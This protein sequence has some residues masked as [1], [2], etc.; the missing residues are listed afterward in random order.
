LLSRREARKIIVVLFLFFA[1]PYQLMNAFSINHNKAYDSYRM[2]VN[3]MRLKIN[4][5][6]QKSL[7]CVLVAANGWLKQKEQR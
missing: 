5:R 4:T 6:N 7:R 1:V 2:P 3:L